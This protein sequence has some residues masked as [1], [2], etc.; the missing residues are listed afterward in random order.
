MARPARPPPPLYS[1]RFTIT[2]GE[3]CTAANE[4]YALHGPQS[5]L[6]SLNKDYESA[7]SQLA[8]VSS[9]YEAAQREAEQQVQPRLV[10]AACRRVR[11][12]PWVLLLACHELATCRVVLLPLSCVAA[13]VA[14]Y[15]AARWD[16]AEEGYLSE[17]AELQEAVVSRSSSLRYIVY[18]LKLFTYVVYVITNRSEIAELQEAV[19]SRSSSLRCGAGFAIRMPAF[20]R[21]GVSPASARL[22]WYYR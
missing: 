14:R 8:A 17:I 10:A 16:S 19:V 20:Q 5:Q 15:Q 3:A 4:R 7:R 11:P 18:I 1:T 9:Y 22:R 2:Q 13:S 12:G 6:S 21:P